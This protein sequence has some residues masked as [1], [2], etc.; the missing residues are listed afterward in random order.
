MGRPGT[1][2]VIRVEVRMRRPVCLILGASLWV[3]ACGGSG[4]TE[5][6]ARIDGAGVSIQLVAPEGTPAESLDEAIG[7][8]KTRVESMPGVTEAEIEW[9]GERNLTVSLTGEVDHQRAVDLIAVPGLLSLRPVLDQRDPT[10]S[11]EESGGV[12]R[13]DPDTGLTM[14]DHPST[15]AWLASHA[16]NGVVDE[17]L[18]VGATSLTGAQISE[19]TP[20]FDSTAD[21][22]VIRLTFDSAGA[23]AF[24]AMTRESAQYDL[25]VDPRRRIAIVLDG[26]ILSAPWVTSDEGITGG[27]AVITVSSQQEA[28]DLSVKLR[29]GALPVAF[30]VL[31]VSTLD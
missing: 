18:L 24:E 12:E 7:I 14:T 8:I 28:E 30:E 20:L 3:G 13:V 25:Y 6:S 5:P 2:L 23:G 21:Q 9:S 29:Y 10:G 1:R 22:W 19:A 11:E 4:S 15:S 16:G 27:V 31:T 26:V 17:V